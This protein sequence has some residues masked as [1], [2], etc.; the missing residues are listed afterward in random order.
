MTTPTK[1]DWRQVVALLVTDQDSTHNYQAMLATARLAKLHPVQLVGE[2]APLNHLIA[3]EAANPGA[4]ASMMALV[5]SKRTALG[6]PPLEP[7]V[8]EKFDK[9]EYMRDFM[10]KKRQRTNRAAEIENL[11][12]GGRDPLRGIAR[13]EFMRVQAGKWHTELTARV[14][15]ARDAAGGRVPKET[16]TALRAQFWSWVD[17]Q[18]D[19][20]EQEARKPR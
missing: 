10:D 14:Q 4:Y 8:V 5:E 3:L 13:L 17:S 20:A 11:V 7:V 1:E 19:T 6:L 16:L 15:R 2:T 18:L 12:R 9:A